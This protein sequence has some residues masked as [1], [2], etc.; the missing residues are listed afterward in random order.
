MNDAQGIAVKVGDRV[1]YKETRGLAIGRVIRLRISRRYNREHEIAKVQLE[2]PIRRY[3]HGTYQRTADGR[4]YIRDANNEL[5]W[6]QG[7]E[8]TPLTVREVWDGQDNKNLIII[9]EKEDLTKPK[10]GVE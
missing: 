9:P 4:N 6:I 8:K 1:A 5:I 7:A 2:E 3:E 10:K